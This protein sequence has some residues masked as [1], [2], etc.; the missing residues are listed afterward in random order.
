MER[1]ASMD[2][3]E[4]DIQ[5]E[6]PK[7]KLAMFIARYGLW[8]MILLAILI[9][10]TTVSITLHL[11]KTNGT[12]Q[13]DLSRPDY[14][15]VRD[16][17]ANDDVITSFPSTGPL[18]SKAYADYRKLYEQQMN[19]AIENQSFAGDSLSDSALGIEIGPVQLEPEQ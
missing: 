6:I 18:D 1:Q 9:A 17:I 13:L 15:S 4:Q 2:N 7:T 8:A 14:Q 19:K 16:K 5:E 12:A 10:I 3:I 11:Y